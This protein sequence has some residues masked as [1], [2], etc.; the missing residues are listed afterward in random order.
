M[1][2]SLGE[3]LEKESK[4]IGA[5][6]LHS[7]ENFGHL[8]YSAKGTGWKPNLCPCFNSMSIPEVFER[9]ACFLEITGVLCIPTS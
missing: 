3:V 2:L 7:S 4:T 8:M 9:K 5:M 6:K 1:I